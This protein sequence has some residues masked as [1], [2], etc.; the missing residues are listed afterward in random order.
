[1]PSM[2]ILAR[3]TFSVLTQRVLRQYWRKINPFGRQICP[4]RQRHVQRFLRFSDLP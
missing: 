1:M 3:A 2:K 4:L